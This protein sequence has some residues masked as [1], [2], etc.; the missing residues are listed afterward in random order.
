MI[1]RRRGTR[2]TGTSFISLSIISLIKFIVGILVIMF[3]AFSFSIYRGN[4]VKNL[5]GPGS[6]RSNVHGVAVADDKFVVD[7]VFATKEIQSLREEF[8]KR[9]GGKGEANEML[10]RGVRHPESRKIRLPSIK[11]DIPLDVARTADRLIRAKEENRSFVMAFGGYSITVGRGNFFQ[12]SYPF[13]MEN[14]LKDLV[15][16]GL[17]MN[18][19]VRNAAIGGT[20]S[21]PYGWCMSNLLG[22]DADVVSWEFGLN[23]GRDADGLESYV[24]HAMSMPHSPKFLLMDNLKGRRNQ[25]F[26]ILKSYADNGANIDSL[27]IDYETAVKSFVDKNVVKESFKNLNGFNRW[28]EWG[29]KDGCPGK[30]SWHLKLQSHELIGWLLAMHLIDAIEIA[31]DV[32][33][34]KEGREHLRTTSLP[35]LP[36]GRNLPDP[37]SKFDSSKSG[38][39]LRFGVKS[40]GSPLTNETWKMNTISCRT[41]YDPILSG[42]L[43]DIVLSGMVEHKDILYDRTENLFEKGWVLDVGLLERNT[44]IKVD[45]C[46][47]LGY[48]DMK[49]SLYGLASSGPLMMKIPWQNAEKSLSGLPIEGD[50]A[51]RWFKSLTICEV[52]EKRKGNPCKID[53]DI[54]FDVGGARV[55]KIDVLSFTGVKYLGQEICFSID[56][57]PDAKVTKHGGE[58]IIRFDASVQN[59]D[60]NYE[61]ACSISHVIWENL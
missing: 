34:D 47:G 18:F 21:F 29:G 23:E 30:N 41:S 49:K 51:S 6:I 36:R 8:Y 61:G 24:R 26:D 20:P 10:N 4:D 45:K 7:E 59:T 52:N 16:R 46:G 57:P 2:D 31:I 43:K 27:V 53:R 35:P 58:F 60:L 12:Q 13:V 9:Y 17:K 42:D 15:Q 37:V 40:S 1:G 28:N 48:I 22:D 5:N 38:S 33:K 25:R 44:K 11:Y 3:G 32:G 14:I 19:T 50:A 54:S 55:S 56:I 39:S